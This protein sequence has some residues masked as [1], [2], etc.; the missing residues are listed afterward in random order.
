MAV[1]KKT[2]R[3]AKKRLLT[4]KK[5]RSKQNKSRKHRNVQRGG[6]LKHGK[7]AGK[8]VI[9][10]AQKQEKPVT[11]G[12]PPLPPP[13]RQP[14]GAQSSYKNSPNLGAA[15]ESYA[16]NPKVNP[17]ALNTPQKFITHNAVSGEVFT[18]PYNTKQTH[19]KRN[20]GTVFSIPLLEEGAPP[21]PAR[22]GKALNRSA[23]GSSVNSES[24][25]SPSYMAYRLPNDPYSRLS[26]TG[27]TPSTVSSGSPEY[28]TLKLNDPNAY[29]PNA[30][31]PYS[32]LS[33]TGRKPSTVSSGSR[34]YNIL[35]LNLNPGQ[36]PFIVP[37]AMY[38]LEPSVS[39]GIY[40]QMSA[41]MQKK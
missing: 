41:M 6:A 26:S 35:K 28:N 15:L 36:K 2:K 31:D 3:N 32:R 16:T 9:P 39:S 21:R 8:V 11:T 30:Y 12:A 23:S 7:P 25:V 17:D 37:N 34:E 19:L 29:D 20:G 18:I 10:D 22:P 1:V 4:K 38:E 14:S 27:R 33:N 40:D 13:R 5:Y 24:S